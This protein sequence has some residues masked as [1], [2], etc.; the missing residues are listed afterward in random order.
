MYSNF[1]FSWPCSCPTLHAHLIIADPSIHWKRK[2]K[3]QQ[4]QQEHRQ[5]VTAK[6]Q[7]T[8]S[9][10]RLD[11]VQTGSLPA[12]L[13][14]LCMFVNLVP[15]MTRLEASRRGVRFGI[16]LFLAFP[17]SYCVRRI[18]LHSQESALIRRLS[19]CNAS[20]LRVVTKSSDQSS[21]SQLLIPRFASLRVVRVCSPGLAV[22]ACLFC[23]PYF[24]PL[25][26]KECASIWR[27]FFVD[28]SCC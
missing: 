15:S 22:S 11:P 16:I 21:L 3:L 19:A 8:P 28:I 23:K 10:L 2:Q 9:L 20:A 14:V 18:A 4:Q 26:V 24:L 17:W 27:K 12:K 13:N 6:I 5:H 7:G 1:E 25:D